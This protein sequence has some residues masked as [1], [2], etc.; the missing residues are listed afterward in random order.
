MDLV[1]ASGTGCGG[2]PGTQQPSVG[3][4]PDGTGIFLRY[5]G[6]VAS[7]P[8]PGDWRDRTCS[9]VLR[10]T[11]PPGITIALHRSL[12]V[13]YVKVKGTA[14]ATFLANFRFANGTPQ[15]TARAGFKDATDKT[16]SLPHSTSNIIFAPCEGTVDVVVDQTVTVSGSG[17][18][19]AILSMN[20]AEHRAQTELYLETQTC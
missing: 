20:Y 7:Y 19:E 5:A 2:L 6:L 14:D 11:Y 13:G 18:A 17:N 16:W 9:T 8:G 12:F 3:N 1:K 15:G 10:F 4:L